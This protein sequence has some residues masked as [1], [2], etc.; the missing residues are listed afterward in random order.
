MHL[1]A[2]AQHII[3]TLGDWGYDAWAVGGCV[4]DSLRRV[5]PKDYDIC[6]N[7]LPFQTM[8]CFAGEKLLQSGLKHGTVTV[9]KY[10]E[11]VE[12]T[13]LRT[14]GKYTDGR[15]PQEVTF[16]GNLAA[17]LARRDFTI[18][19][20]AWNLEGGYHDLFGGQK[21]LEARLVRC[22]GDPRRRFAEDSL[23]IIRALRFASD[24]DFT[25]EENTA[26][27]IDELKDSLRRVSAERLATEFFK[28][29]CGDAASRVIAEYIDT[30]RV[31][32]PEI[33]PKVDNNLQIIITQLP[34]DPI[35]RLAALLPGGREAGEVAAG[36]L[37][38]SR[39]MSRKLAAM[40]ALTGG[41]LPG[42]S[43]EAAAMLERVS[44][45][46]SV[47]QL[48]IKG[49]EIALLGVPQGPEMGAVMRCL[50]EQ[51]ALGNCLN[52]RQSL[53]EAA[54]SLWH[55]STLADELGGDS[56]DSL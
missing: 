2:A 14:D 23:R 6:T 36:R 25:I 46:W 31:I 18:N 15:R 38:L 21:D 45:C 26:A 4:R 48:A 8:E 12:V 11:P 27:A 52:G 44:D 56:D 54:E 5:V 9:V 1:S 41:R 7:A 39:T 13:T 33:I 35:A 19:A 22:V 43:Y 10:G 49:N 55:H 20:M 30:L 37:K 50:L 16:V 40:G 24:L 47:S 51:V 29:L 53:R 42:N 17:D 34:K 3:D 28:L 32:I